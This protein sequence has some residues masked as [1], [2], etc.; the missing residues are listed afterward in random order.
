MNS[1]SDGMRATL[2]GLAAFAILGAGLLGPGASARGQDS[3]EIT[4]LYGRGVHAFFAGHLSQAEEMFTDCVTSG[5]TDPRVYYFRGVTRLRQGRQH[6]AEEDLRI[7]GTLEARDPGRRYAIGNALQRIQ[8]SERRTLEEFRRQAR[9]EKVQERRVQTRARYEQL[10]NREADV[11]HQSNPVPMEQL[12]EPSVDFQD[13]PGTTTPTFQSTETPEESVIVEEP[14]PAETT[15]TPAPMDPGPMESADDD[16]FGTPAEPTVETPAEEAAETTGDDP[17][18]A[19]AAYEE[20][21]TVEPAFE[22]SES[23]DLFGDPAPAVDSPPAPEADPFG[24]A[25]PAEE[26]TVEAPIEAPVEE[27]A[28]VEETEEV[29]ADPFGAI[30]ESAEEE[31]PFEEVPAEEGEATG[32][33]P[34]GADAADTETEE[35]TDETEEPAADDPFGAESTESTDS[36]DSDPFG[37]AADEAAEGESTEGEAET[38]ETET[39]ETESEEDESTDEGDADDPFGEF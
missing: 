1:Y 26:A 23:G 8:G 21:P 29:E 37:G 39:E 2:R 4:A 7:A 18:G 5:S 3:T 15:H 25:E 38:E 20:A 13:A 22:A 14:A 10:R 9:V 12:I 30:E 31:A 35:V 6:E 36:A 27:A 19:D 32:D 33:D 17:F 28:P 34:F 16:L 11:L 24:A